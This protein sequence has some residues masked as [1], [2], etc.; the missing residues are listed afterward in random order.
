MYAFGK[1][2]VGK[3][4]PVPDMQTLRQRDQLLIVKMGLVNQG[5]FDHITQIQTP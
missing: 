3:I 4:M 2:L 1:L 5:Q